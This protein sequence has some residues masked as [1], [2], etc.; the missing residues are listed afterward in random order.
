MGATD[1]QF[2]F[3][4]LYEMELFTYVSRLTIYIYADDS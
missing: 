2:I 3:N 1:L 4:H